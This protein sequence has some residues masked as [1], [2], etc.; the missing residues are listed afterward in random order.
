[1]IRFLVCM[2]TGSM[3]GCVFVGTNPPKHQTRSSVL[4]FILLMRLCT[5]LENPSNPFALM[6]SSGRHLSTCHVCGFVFVHGV[7]SCVASSG[8]CS[9]TGCGFH[10]C[11]LSANH[12]RYKKPRLLLTWCQ[13]V[14][15]CMSGGTAIVIFGVEKVS[16]AIWQ[17]CAILVFELPRWPLYQCLTTAQPLR[18]TLTPSLTLEPPPFTTSTPST[19]IIRTQGGELLCTGVMQS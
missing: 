7:F 5:V 16:G 18:L 9:G 3:L 2:W 19:R 6:I 12:Q 11:V 10:T 4:L 14:F 8:V 15:R 17:T 1:M 13:V